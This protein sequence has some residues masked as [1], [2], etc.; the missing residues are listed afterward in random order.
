M[1]SQNSIDHS[2]ALIEYNTAAGNAMNRASTDL[3]S[4][5]RLQ[6]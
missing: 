6:E 5:A 2:T 4:A 3:G 1:T